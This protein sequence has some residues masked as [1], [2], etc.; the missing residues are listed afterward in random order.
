MR[1]VVGNA[2]GILARTY[3]FHTCG[4]GPDAG[5]EELEPMAEDN[6]AIC[7]WFRDRGAPDC[8][9]CDANQELAMGRD[10]MESS[11]PRISRAQVTVRQSA[12]E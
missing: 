2:T 9:G 6:W 4:G 11:V 5:L 8:V 3:P 12:R 10:A 7:W 1:R